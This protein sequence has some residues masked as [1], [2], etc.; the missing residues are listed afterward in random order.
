MP[1]VIEYNDDSSDD[2]E[3]R[4]EPWVVD[5]GTTFHILSEDE[6]AARGYVK[7]PIPSS[8]A[9]NTANGQAMATQMAEFPFPGVQGLLYAVILPSSPCLLSLCQLCV[10]EGFTFIYAAAKRPLLV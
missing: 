2:G 4:P 10:H 3:D 7:V 5:S 9:F 6:V 1:S 8:M